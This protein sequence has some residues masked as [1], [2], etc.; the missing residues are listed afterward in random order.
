MLQVLAP[1]AAAEAQSDSADADAALSA[2][3]AVQELARPQLPQPVG[4]QS[5][6]SSAE[7]QP[8]PSAAQLQADDTSFQPVQKRRGRQGRAREQ[9]ASHLRPGPAAGAGQHST[10]ATLPACNGAL[11]P[12]SSAPPALRPARSPPRM[13]AWS[14]RPAAEPAGSPAQQETRAASSRRP[15]PAAFLQTAAAAADEPAAELRSQQVQSVSRLSSA[16]FEVRSHTAAL[17]RPVKLTCSCIQGGADEPECAYCLDA[18][19]DVLFRPCLHEVLCVAC[20]A[21]IFSAASNEAL[22]PVCRVPVLSTYQ[23]VQ[24]W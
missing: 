8:D 6:G 17:Q 4:L 21:Q 16:A 10:P 18:T 1:A 9:P 20:A 13:P 11:S 5:P 7:C 15:Q 22:C 23:K 24:L 12:A 14:Q 3:Q 19:P 2:L